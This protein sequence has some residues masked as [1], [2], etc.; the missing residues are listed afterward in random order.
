MQ[1]GNQIV[2]VSDEQEI[3]IKTQLQNSTKETNRDIIGRQ[4]ED[5]LIYK[6]D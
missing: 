5:K 3:R 1:S 4:K 6:M 2:I